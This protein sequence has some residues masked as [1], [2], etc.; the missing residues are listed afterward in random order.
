MNI[1]HL[2]LLNRI[3]CRQILRVGIGAGEWARTLGRGVG[4]VL[5]A[6]LPLFRSLDECINLFARLL[7]SRAI[8]LLELVAYLVQC[9][10][11]ARLVYVIVGDFSR[12]SW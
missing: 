12:S 6:L 10:Q 3:C 9:H 2:L 5:V 7:Q 11:V 8:L 1:R 4:F